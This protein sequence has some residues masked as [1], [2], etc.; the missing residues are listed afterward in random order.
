VECVVFPRV[1]ENRR[2]LLKDDNIVVLRGRVDRSRGDPKF[3]VDDIQ[4]PEEFKSA[5][6]HSV[7]IRFDGAPMDETSLY[8]LRDFI[9]DKSGRCSLFL[10]LKPGRES[11]ETVIRAS[12]AITIRPDQDVLERM[13]SY[14]SVVEVWK[15]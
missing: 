3:L 2:D 6:V 4:H 5:G 12:S 10:H 14:P 8:Q 1:F 13:Q 11:A 7:H 9:F 15:E